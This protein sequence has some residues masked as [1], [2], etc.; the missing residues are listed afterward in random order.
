MPLVALN[1]LE[2]TAEAAD[3]LAIR[4]ARIR[5]RRVMAEPLGLA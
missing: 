1:Q 5:D 4:A 2:G 3:A